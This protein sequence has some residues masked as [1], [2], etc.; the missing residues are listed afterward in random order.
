V[1]CSLGLGV[2]SADVGIA[3]KP[4]CPRDKGV[5]M[6]R[7]WAGTFVVGA[8]VAKGTLLVVLDASLPGGLI[9]ASGIMRYADD[10]FYHSGVRL[11]LHRLQRTF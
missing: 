11:T 6:H 2:E 1:R 4:P 8:V 10:G 7:V 3:G 5:I 9:E